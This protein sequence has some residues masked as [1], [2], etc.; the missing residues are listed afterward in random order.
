M[1]V[2]IS[3]IV[4]THNRAAYLKKALESLIDQTLHTDLYEIIVVDNASSDGTKRVVSEYADTVSANLRYIYEPVV[5]ESRARNR[6]WH[7][8]QGEYIAYLDDDAVASPR[9]LE[10]FINVFETFEPTPGSLGGRCDP[11][12][13][14]PQPDWLSDRLLGFLSILRWSEASIIINER[15][16]LSACNIAYP[17]ELLKAANGF[18]EDLGRQ[19]NSLRGGVEI[20]LQHQLDSLGHCSVYHPEISVGHHISPSKLTKT[21]FRQRA[22]W[23]GISNAIM[24]D[25]ERGLSLSKRAQL[26]LSRV[27]WSL[28]RL[29]LMFV[30]TNSAHRFRRQCQLLEVAGFISGLWQGQPPESSN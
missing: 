12:W 13:E 5:G 20:G 14:A 30:G 8:A 15:R 6:G 10:M 19:G 24:L 4:C 21:W 17:R 16:G 3:A 26:A 7:N 11:I 22:Y 18:R 1:S 29:V 28:P 27:A 25:P 2:Q 23:Q 9:W